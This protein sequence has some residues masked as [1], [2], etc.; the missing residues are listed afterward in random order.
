MTG[1]TTHTLRPSPYLQRYSTWTS[2][3]P[4]RISTPHLFCPERIG[5][6]RNLTP[7][8]YSSNCCSSC[9][10]FSSFFLASQLLR[11]SRMPL[12][13]SLFQLEPGWIMNISTVG[14]SQ[15]STFQYHQLCITD[16]VENLHS[17]VLL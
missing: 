8:S 4:I 7:Y 9:Y 17:S 1:G 11:P 16:L 15:Y 10:P 13:R 2:Y 6:S 14:F 5:Y 3:F 12:S